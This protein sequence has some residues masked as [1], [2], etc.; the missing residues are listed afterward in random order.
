MLQAMSGRPKVKVIDPSIVPAARKGLSTPWAEHDKDGVFTT[1]YSENYFLL[2]RDND[3]LSS[4]MQIPHLLNRPDSPLSI[5]SLL[6][7]CKR[8]EDSDDTSPGRDIVIDEISSFDR[9]DAVRSKYTISPDENRS[10]KDNAVKKGSRKQE[11]SVH[12]K[13]AEEYLGK[14]NQFALDAQNRISCRAKIS[15]AKTRADKHEVL[16][17]DIGTWVPF[18][19]GKWYERKDKRFSEEM[20]R[21][22]S[23]IHHISSHR[24]N[25]LHARF[26]TKTAGEAKARNDSRKH[27]LPKR[28]EKQVRVDPNGA[29]DGR[30]QVSGRASARQSRPMSAPAQQFRKDVQEK[31]KRGE[32]KGAEMMKDGYKDEDGEEKEEVC[33]QGG[34][35][36]EREGTSMQSV[37][38]LISHSMKETAKTQKDTKPSEDCAG[39]A[40]QS[41]MSQADERGRGGGGEG[42]T[43]AGWRPSSPAAAAC[44]LR[45]GPPPG[46]RLFAPGV[47]AWKNPK[48]YF[49]LPLT[50]LQRITAAGKKSTSIH[51]GGAG[52]RRS[53]G[54]RPLSA[55]LH[56]TS[57]DFPLKTGE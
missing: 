4:K 31:T 2:V 56:R 16:E 51:E 10:K 28:E 35:A 43:A 36:G 24:P 20:R 3:E 14:N 41:L 21:Y 34:A 42:A 39:E 1:E 17:G 46:Y 26:E 5:D 52:V 8:E 6:V 32:K 33:L 45:G 12:T 53:H 57:Q 49:G 11:T 40:D 19:E 29:V 55:P 47:T 25:N 15:T 30:K 23:G 7:G 48:N 44:L 54:E 13:K 27:S 37:A 22:M 38:S 9:G 18:A 50:A